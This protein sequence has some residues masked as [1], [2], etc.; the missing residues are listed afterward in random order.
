MEHSLKVKLTSDGIVTLD[1]NH[2][3][4][5]INPEG[6]HLFGYQFTEL[7]GKHFNIL[8][9]PHD[10]PGEIRDQAVVNNATLK[11]W[12]GTRLV[13]GRRK[14]G[15]TFPSQVSMIEVTLVGKRFFLV[16]IHDLTEWKQVE[17]RFQLVVES[18]PTALVMVNSEGTILLVNQ[19]TEKTFQ[20]HRE[21]LI[22]QP[23]EILIPQRYRENHVEQ[24]KSY[25]ANPSARPM[26]MGRDLFGR[27]KDGTE[28]PV[29]I[30]LNVIRTP[31]SVIVLSSIVDITERK[32][33]D[34]AL[35]ESKLELEKALSAL[36]ETNQEVNAM[37]QQLWQAAKLASVGELAA[38]IA[39]ELNNPL[40]TVSLR[41]ES[42]LARTSADDPRRRG[43]EI[44]NQETRRMGDL[45]S[46]LLQFSRR[47]EE[48]ISTVDL[49]V[50]L[51]HSLELIQHQ[52]R[53]NQIRL[54]RET[55]P[56]PPP[57]YADRQKLRQVFLNLLTNA[58]D[59]MPLGGILTL[60]TGLDS[61]DGGKAAVKIE[62]VD[63]GVG[64]AP[65]HLDKVM[66]P[67]FTT[68]EEGK[69]TGLGLAI[70]RRIVQDHRGTLHIES[71]LKKGTT[72]AILLPLTNESN[73]KGLRNYGS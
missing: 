44:I 55:T 41:L 6:E 7:I 56:S 49:I 46:N 23:V 35:K 15:Q 32:R 63:T 20:Y 65:D 45:V 54:V 5:S 24:R 53:K 64:I 26:G 16:S 19:Q 14:N 70:C 59:A 1:E 73:V 69:G 72:V 50:E 21:E 42:V 43:L 38:G 29:E 51:N 47:G 8:L 58:S 3:I 2:R 28:F 27:C 36:Q 52:L 10:N 22:G 39:H 62:F 40:A 66:D 31:E 18:S 33:A 34:D 68:K 9:D 37:T 48:K 13:I 4:Q 67:F 25:F 57:I 30:G 71:V 60:R 12:Q 61:L 11:V 17:M